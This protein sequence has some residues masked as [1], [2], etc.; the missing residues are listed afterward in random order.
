MVDAIAFRMGSVLKGE[1]SSLRT[2][3]AP[4]LPHG[5]TWAAAILPAGRSIGRGRE[6]LSAFTLVGAKRM[7]TVFGIGAGAAAQVP[8]LGESI[9]RGVWRDIGSPFGTERMRKAIA[10]AM[11]AS[12]RYCQ[13]Q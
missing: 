13:Q 3:R 8:R 11:C 12:P 4:I 5:G 9:S 2:L 1:P 10:R 6:P 7:G